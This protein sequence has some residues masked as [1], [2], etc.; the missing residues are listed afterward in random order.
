MGC[1]DASLN[2][3]LKATPPTV[4]SNKAPST[5]IKQKNRIMPFPVTSDNHKVRP[6]KVKHR[7]LTARGNMLQTTITGEQVIQK[8][9]RRIE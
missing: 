7:E 2:R 6:E 4:C 8:K 5:L 1:N 9:I 3:N